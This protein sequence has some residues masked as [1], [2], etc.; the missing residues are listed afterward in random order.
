[1]LP[2]AIAADDQTLAA[3]AERVMSRCDRLACCSEEAGAVTRRYLSH[4]MQEVHHTVGDW[5]RSAGLRVRVDAAGNLIG[6]RPGPEGSRVLL[7]GSHLDSVPNAGRYDGVLGVLAALAV[8]ELLGAAP[9]PFHLDVIGFSEEEG[10]RYAL[11][12]LGSRAVCGGFDPAWLERCDPSGVSMRQAIE[13][14]GLAPDKIPEAAYQPDEVIG[15]VEPHLEQGPVLERA[16][17]PVGVVSGIAGQTRMRLRFL[18]HAQHAG[19]T[20]MHG[21]RD[22]LLGAARMI[23]ET[24]RIGAGADGLRA[25][26]GFLRV[27]PNATNVI[28][29]EVELSLDVRHPEDALR[30]RAVDTLL[31]L[32]AEIARELSLGFSVIDHVVQEACR[33]DPRLTSMLHDACLARGYD[34]PMLPSGAGHD[35]APL[36]ERFPVAMLFLRHPGGVSHHPDERVDVPDV[37]VALGVLLQFIHLLAESESQ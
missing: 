36:S 10:V 12:Y 24:Q 6:R 4:P 25:T 19:T 3:A 37:Q 34:A 1:M 16:G 29:G 9:L 35:A 31:E 28:P 8:A 2:P 22:A 30:R 14:F 13:A 26:V 21:R 27:A 23:C 5:M 7:L 20:P 32:G 11:P 33:V 18:G 15:F 17:L